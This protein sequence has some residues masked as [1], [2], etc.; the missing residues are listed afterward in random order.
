[1]GGGPAS[2]GPSPSALAHGLFV[3][4]GSGDRTEGA[5]DE[6][7]RAFGGTMLCPGLSHWS[8]GSLG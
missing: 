4:A 8:K 2:P 3:F 6:R 7:M 1:M 5:A